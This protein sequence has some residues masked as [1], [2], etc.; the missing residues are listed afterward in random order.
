MIDG[1]NIEQ[2]LNIKTEVAFSP[3]SIQAA[4]IENTPEAKKAPPHFREAVGK[5]IGAWFDPKSFEQDPTAYERLG[6]RT[7]KK[8]MPTSGD[9]VYRL[10]WKKFGTPNMTGDGSK[11]ALRNYEFFTRVFETAHLSLFA[12]YTAAI[13][14]ELQAGR[15]DKAAVITGLN[16][17]VNVYPIMVQRYN[18][19]RL[20]KAIN[21]VHEHEKNK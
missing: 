13:T 11:Q 8:Y 17:L 1:A 4:I 21:K 10:V 7:F 12:L 3:N 2:G 5:I 6:V 20:Y 9:L 15:L 19:S 18:R 16:T 14:E